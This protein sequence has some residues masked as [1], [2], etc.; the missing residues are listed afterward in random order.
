MTQKMPEPVSRGA[1]IVFEGCDR[2]GKTTQCKKV[3]EVLK[4]EGKNIEFC[5]FP[6]MYYEGQDSQRFLRITEEIA[7]VIT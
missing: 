6:G 4:E 3:V 1:L 7:F 5:R 2:S